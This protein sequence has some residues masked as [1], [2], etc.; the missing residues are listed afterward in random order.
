ML[1]KLIFGS[2][3]GASI[4]YFP[5]DFKRS[6]KSVQVLNQSIRK[7]QIRTTFDPNLRPQLWASQE[8]MITTINDLAS[9]AEI[10]L[11]GIN[12]GEILMGSREPEAIADF[13]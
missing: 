12:E 6:A 10:V 1:I 5:S 4:G 7:N 11:P 3:D 9:H 8:E 13:I 2:K